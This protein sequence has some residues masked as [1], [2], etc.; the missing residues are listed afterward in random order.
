M[1]AVIGQK[2]IAKMSTVPTDDFLWVIG[3]ATK[4]IP[5]YTIK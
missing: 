1:M 5:P 2:N 3:D 4:G